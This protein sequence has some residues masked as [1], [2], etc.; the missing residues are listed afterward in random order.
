MPRRSRGSETPSRSPHSRNA[1]R[2]ARATL[3]QLPFPRVRA[4][5]SPLTYTDGE[6]SVA[7]AGSPTRA[8]ARRGTLRPPVRPIERGETLASILEAFEAMHARSRTFAER[9]RQVFPSGITHD[10]RIFS[11]WPIYV[12]RAAGARK[13]DVDGNEYVDYIG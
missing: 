1:S 4:L 7:R 13:W 6:V 8:L 9:A 3:L 5:A 12:E 11:P 10:I 2:G